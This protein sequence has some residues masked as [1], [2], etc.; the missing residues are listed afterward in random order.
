MALRDARVLR[1]R[2]LA[3]EDWDS[4]GRAYAEERKGYFDVVHT[5]ELWQNRL[6]MTAG[7]ESDAARRQAF[8]KW[9]EDRTRNPDTFL[10]G[11][12][13]PLDGD[14]RRRFFGED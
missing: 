12:G 11:P 5:M 10:S 9:R 13:A 3:D 7:P 1:D 2:L 14:A 8:G 4:A 6:L